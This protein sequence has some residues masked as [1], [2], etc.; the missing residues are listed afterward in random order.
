MKLGEIWTT[1]VASIFIASPLLAE[2][3]IAGMELLSSIAFGGPETLMAHIRANDTKPPLIY[4]QWYVDQIAKTNQAVAKIEQAH[5]EF[6]RSVLKSLEDYAPCL[7]RQINWRT[8]E[9]QLVAL[10]DLA[11]WF[12]ARFGYGNAILVHRLHDMAS[13]HIAYLTSDMSYPET[14][15]NCWVARLV[16]WPE[17][18]RRNVNALNIELGRSLFRVS[19]NVQSTIDIWDPV[20]R[21]MLAD[22]LV[23]QINDVWRRKDSDIETWQRKNG[24]H[25]IPQVGGVLRKAVPDELAFFVDDDVSSC[26]PFTA[27]NIWDRKYHRKLYLGLGGH[28]IRKTRYLLLFRQKVGGFPTNPP[29]PWL[30]CD[31]STPIDMAFDM[32]WNPYRPEFGNIDDPAYEVFASLRENSF[33]DE[34]MRMVNLWKSLGLRHGSAED[35]RA[36]ALAERVNFINSELKMVPPTNNV[37]PVSSKAIQCFMDAGTLCGMIVKHHVAQRNSDGDESRRLLFEDK[38][39]RPIAVCDAIFMESIKSMNRKL[40]EGLIYLAL[41]REVWPHLYAGSNAVGDCCVADKNYIDAINAFDVDGSGYHFIR[42]NVI[43]HI[44][45]TTPNRDIRDI[46][47]AIDAILRAIQQ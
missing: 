2:T 36:S 25:M 22:R 30:E 9:E 16:D 13:V 20:Q 26:N 34:D 8:R 33:C 17:D 32:A 11:D 10:L 7:R 43:V 47:K 19:Q 14:R 42:N 35:M 41:P 39:G 27:L 37:H 3:Q 4:S 1:L 45:S 38:S 15:L 5:R 24:L 21:G 44:R 6:G 28:N 18:V 46:A 12:G 29:V 40:A 23:A 31:Y